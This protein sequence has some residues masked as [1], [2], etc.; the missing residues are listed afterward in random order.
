MALTE[1]DVRE[2]LRLIDESELDELRIETD[3]FKLHVV[4]GEAA[5]EVAPE[6][7]PAATAARPSGGPSSTI[8]APMPGTFYRSEG[9]GREPFVDIGARVEPDTVVC[10][11]EI[12]KMMNSV[13]AGVSGTIVEICADDAQLVGDGEALFRVEAAP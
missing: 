13:P 2:I 9:P 11:I 7:S 1:A 5:A 10:I 12:M 4:R 3:D 8:D 6:A